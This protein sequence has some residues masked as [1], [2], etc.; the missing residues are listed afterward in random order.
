MSRADEGVA[1]VAE[2]G[3]GQR[4]GEETVGEGDCEWREGSVDLHMALPTLASFRHDLNGA[5]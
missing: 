4:M 1:G 2:E 5:R 3:R